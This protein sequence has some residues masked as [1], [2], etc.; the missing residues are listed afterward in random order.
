MSVFGEDSS[1]MDTGDDKS[2][3]VQ[4][5]YKPSI[6]SNR[7]YPSV[8]SAEPHF[9]PSRQH[10]GSTSTST[11][12]SADSSPTTTISTADSSSLSD[13][14][15]NSSPES[16]ISIVPLS[17]FTLRSPEEMSMSPPLSPLFSYNQPLSPGKR[18]RNTKNL[19]LNMAAPTRQPPPPPRVMTAAAGD[20]HFQSAPPSPSFIVPPKPPRK[21]PSNLGL[22]I[23]TPAAGSLPDKMSKSLKIVPPTPSTIRTNGLRH[24]QSSPSLSVF[25]PTR[26][27]VPG[28]VRLPPVT[29][30]RLATSVQ[31][32]HRRQKS[33][34]LD[35]G[36]SDS[37]MP[38]CVSSAATQA[39]DELEEE[40][41]D[42]P[43]SNEAKSPAY[44]AGPVCIYDPLV[45]L[46]LEPSA[47]EASKFDVIFNVA[48]EVKN[49]FHAANDAVDAVRSAESINEMNTAPPDTA[50]SEP[51]TATS[52]STFQTAFETLSPPSGSASPTTPKANQE[53]SGP[54]YIHI[55]WDHNTSIVDDLMRLVE[56]V[57]ER[58]R[59]GKRVLIHCQC[60]VSRSASLIVAYGLYKDPTLTVQEAYDAVKQRSRWIGPNMS[61]I[62]QLSEFRAQL[63]K[64]KRQTGQTGFRSWRGSGKGLSGNGRAN[65][66]PSGE[67]S[68]PCISIDA[69][70]A[71]RE[72]PQTAPLPDDRDRTPI[73]SGPYEDQKSFK[74][75]DKMRGDITPGPSS[76]PSGFAWIPRGASVESHGG[77]WG[78]GNENL[79][80]VPPPL[81]PSSAFFQ[82][83]R[84]EQ[85][86]AEGG[87]LSTEHMEVIEATPQPPTPD[88][89]SPRATE[90]TANPFQH[91]RM[92]STFGFGDTKVA[93]AFVDPR[94]P[95]LR[96]EAPIVRS[97]FDVL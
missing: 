86:I 37:V 58:V 7:S 49:P 15:P 83:R 4:S 2:A 1:A 10:R 36:C 85:P 70:D 74:L 25:S 56:V 90:F 18:A 35:T 44:P 9:D 22:T 97:I 77:S 17:S 51:Q 84:E 13:P 30:Q 21:R 8:G 28:G 42:A 71:G 24:Y 61:L 62:Y 69:L 34:T 27:Q 59:Q 31:S 73:K 82:E 41:A 89:L 3:P 55:P 46:Y 11:S 96:G 53:A 48:R 38:D 67:S 63:T 76:A 45:Y 52:I 78:S 39:L 43:L 72:P 87:E 20:T 92:T 68:R 33:V 54:E 81:P 29:S 66:V 75:A 40:D 93:E 19:S 65:T 60:G 6:Q 5:N 91:T 32:S 14:S 94:S 16:P 95:A 57:D 23:K 64:T 12:D 88:I 47:E 80:F 26:T 50:S 79:G